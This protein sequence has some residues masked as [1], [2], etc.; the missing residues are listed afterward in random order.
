MVL[1]VYVETYGDCKENA[2]QHGLGQ[3][4]FGFELFSGF[5]LLF[6]ALGLVNWEGVSGWGGIG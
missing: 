5:D 4:V 2:A 6:V 3:A 1:Q